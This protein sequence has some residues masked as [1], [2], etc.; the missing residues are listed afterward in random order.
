M[1]FSDPEW[2]WLLLLLPLLAL[3][4]GRQG[5]AT[6]VEYSSADLVRE[7][8]RIRAFRPG[9][10]LL[11]F[12]FLGLACW[13][14]GMA[15][16]QIGHGRTEIQ[17]SGIDIV[18]ALDLSGSMASLDL[19]LDGQPA[20][21]LEVVKSVTSKF[22]EARPNDR[23]GIIAFA[24]RPYLVSPLTLDHGW[25]LTNLER[26]KLGFIEDSTAI[27]SAVAASVNRLR[28]QKSKSKIIILLTDGMNNAGK[29]MPQTAAD[30]AKTL[31]IKLY[32][33][34]VGVRGEAPMPVEDAFGR[35]HL[36]MI[37]VDVD[38]ETLK[39]IAETTG[40]QFYRATDTDSLREIYG[41]IDKLEKS[42]NTMKTF[43]S[44][45]EKTAWF[46]VPGLAF[47]M[48]ETLLAQTRFRRLP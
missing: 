9:R 25:L 42:V 1:R 5:I 24:G 13:I 15:R 10:L 3:W 4:R 44:Y 21:R 29:I 28:E 31:G 18:L 2:L 8:S 35:K 43:E 36:E 23:I 6:A 40:G 19:K 30:V 22:I 26:L 37:K 46:L 45:E 34:G 27:G 39:K 41:Q 20:S 32:T 11:A 16:P 48:M 47:V 12:W 33:I 7:A 14:V 17:A 38:E